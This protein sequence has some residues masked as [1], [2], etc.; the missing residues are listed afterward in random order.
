MMTV[1][2]VF[3]ATAP[4]AGAATLDSNAI[5]TF[6]PDTSITL[7][8]DP[9][10]P[11]PENPV[12][13]I[14]P[15]NPG[16]TPNPGTAGPLSLDFASSFDFGDQLISSKDAVYTAAAQKLS[17]GSDRPNFVQ[18]SDKRGTEEGWTLRVQ[19]DS[20]LMSE[21]TNKELV[22]AEITIENG[23][24]VSNSASALPSEV[25]AKLNLSDLAQKNVVV[26]SKGEGN[27]TYVYRMGDDATKNSSVKLSVPGSTSKMS[28]KYQTT[29][30]WT[31]SD[32][33]TP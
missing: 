15:T 18:V 2:G 7:P 20:Q 1:A 29:L 26:A 24:I 22:G 11:D 21:K 30:T 27:G 12:T 23:S 31:L 16:G 19:Q 25:T 32:I 10:N 6:S 14:D 9:M 33:P 28:E 3:L 13:P 8:V 5:V 4:N 17:D